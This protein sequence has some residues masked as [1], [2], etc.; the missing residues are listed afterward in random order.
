MMS[1]TN[2]K[3]G[4]AYIRVS[5]DD[6]TELSPDAQL[7]MILESAK[8]DGVV[9]PPELVFMEDRGRSGRRADNRPEFQRMIATAR[10]TPSPFSV[11]YVWKFSRFARNQ[12]ESTFY[13]GILRKKCGVT[14]KSVSEPIMEGMF[15]R[16]VEMII[17]WSDEFYSINLAGE[18]LRGMTQKALEHGYQSTPCLGYKSVG[19]GKP[20]I[21]DELQYSIVEFIHQSYH[22]GKDLMQI[23]REANA[24]GYRT[25]RGNPFDPRSVKLV[26]TN[27]F[28]IGIVKW[29]DIV[30]QGTHECRESVTSLFTDNQKRLQHEYRP[31]NRRE[32]SS[33]RHWLSGVL[34]CNVCGASLGYNKV[35]NKPSSD[36]FNCWKYAKGLHEGSCSITV[37]K[38]E[39]TVLESLH[40]ALKTGKIEFTY[41]PKEDPERDAKKRTIQ[42]HLNRLEMKE[43]RIRD[44][45]EGGVDTLEEYKNN[46]ERLQ[47]ERDHLLRDLS[48][49][50]Q[51]VGDTSLGKEELLQRIQSVYD[52]LRS[53]NV[54]METKGNALRQIVQKITYDR[55]TGTMFFYYY[56]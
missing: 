8:N 12:E 20:F 51:K 16:L 41:L 10:Q 56:M 49:L 26:L 2:L 37:K 36:F 21:I 13:K 54:D 48:L 14:I 39:R 9:I 7:R 27:S 30:F 42:A 23:V 19:N 1:D 35:G 18:V 22:D 47:K 6:Q 32:V 4:A 28:Y 43:M 24:R 29:K 52:L 31:H 17:E 34:K 5:T 25:R 50:E 38:A 53:E 46:K 45:Y 44:A 3:I 15:G 40:T 33:C 55:K 11:L